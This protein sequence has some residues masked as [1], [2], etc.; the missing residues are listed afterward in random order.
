M[1]G[2]MCKCWSEVCGMMDGSDEPARDMK[3][4]LKWSVECPRLPNGMG[5][6]HDLRHPVSSEKNANAG[7]SMD[8]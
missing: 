4:K 2:I 7:V 6:Q 3:I 5:N 8:F 1:G